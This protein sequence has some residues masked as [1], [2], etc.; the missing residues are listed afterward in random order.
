MASS[1]GPGAQRPSGRQVF[2][3]SLSGAQARPFIPR[4]RSDPPAYQPVP[5][6]LLEFREHE[7]KDV[8]ERRL[9][10]LWISL[11][12]N[13]KL[14][15]DESGDQEI[16]EQ[17]RV[18]DEHSLT[19]ERAERLQEMYQDELLLR[20]RKHTAGFLHRNITWKEFEKYA[21]AKESG[22]SAC[23]VCGGTA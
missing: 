12:K 14:N 4:L 6:N 15:H 19:K 16:A 17:Y 8:R 20:F 10:R 18:E 1:P 5:H 9:R 2:E 3:A 21:D 23:L 22:E 11:P 13:Q 7:G